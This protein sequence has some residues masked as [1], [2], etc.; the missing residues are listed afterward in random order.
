MQ[1]TDAVFVVEHEVR[2]VKARSYT[3]DEIAKIGTINDTAAIALAVL[4][5]VIGTLLG[6]VLEN[7]PPWAAITIVLG[8]VAAGAIWVLYLTRVP[9]S[10]WIQTAPDGYVRQV[11]RTGRGARPKN[12]P[13]ER[14]YPGT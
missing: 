14:Y 1:P 9:A 3:Y 8:L 10:R 2:T 13:G 6:L 5:A 4:S 11:E 12:P 7:L